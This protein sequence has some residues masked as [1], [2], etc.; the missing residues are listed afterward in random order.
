MKLLTKEQ[1]KSYE[2]AKICY[3]CKGNF[4]HKYANEKNSRKVTD[5]CHYT[6]EYR[7]TAHSIGE[8]TVKH[9]DKKC[10]ICGIACKVCDCFFE[11][12]NFKDGLIEYKCLCCMFMLRFLNIY[13]L[14][15]N[16]NNEFILL[17]QKVVYPYE[18][19]DDCEKLVKLT[20]T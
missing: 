1:Q 15:S 6:G 9:D 20:A 11:Y 4:E 17:L 5:H 7:S 13:N 14:S 12:K 19:M 8:N 10:E 18:Y 3:I 16:D 2:N